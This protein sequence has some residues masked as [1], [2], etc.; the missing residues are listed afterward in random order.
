LNENVPQ[1]MLKILE[2]MQNTPEKN[3]QNQNRNSFQSE[4]I[5]NLMKNLITP[6]QKQVSNI[7][8]SSNIPQESRDEK[9]DE[10][11][12]IPTSQNPLKFEEKNS[13]SFTS[14]CKGPNN[15]NMN[16]FI[17]LSKVATMCNQLN[18]EEKQKKDK[19]EKEDEEEKSFDDLKCKSKKMYSFIF[20]YMFL[21]ILLNRKKLNWG[22]GHF[23]RE[24]YAKVWIFF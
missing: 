15:Q 5:L 7:I 6:Q 2:A 24:H 17:L 11:K 20:F 22:C 12:E 13:D 4:E 19:A 1:N 18:N 8:L 16:D 21:L 3:S 23:E 10:T 14:E 9:E